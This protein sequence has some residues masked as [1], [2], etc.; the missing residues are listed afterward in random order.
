M[1]QGESELGRSGRTMSRRGG[2][3]PVV[4]VMVE[5]RD[6]QR[7]QGWAEGLAGCLRSAQ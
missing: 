4:G 7:A 5:A 1:S 6:A 3:G 2:T